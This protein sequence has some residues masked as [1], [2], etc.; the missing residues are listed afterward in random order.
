MPQVPQVVFVDNQELKTA[1]RLIGSPLAHLAKNDGGNDESASLS[2]L[3][4]DTNDA[5]AQ[6]RDAVGAVIAR[7]ESQI[8]LIEPFGRMIEALKEAMKAGGK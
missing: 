1:R 4:Y 6:D 5:N 3:V 7:L 2:D 8:D